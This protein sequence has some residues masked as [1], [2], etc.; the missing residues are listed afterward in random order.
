M[1]QTQIESGLSHADILQ[2]VLRGSDVWN[3]WRTENSHE[4]INL[5]L[6]DLSDASLSNTNLSH[7]NFSFAIP[8]GDRFKWR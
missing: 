6:A 3:Q 8:R 7:I 4:S 1:S 2:L 5:P